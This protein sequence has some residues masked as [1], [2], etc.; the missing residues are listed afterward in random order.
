MGI[1]IS[2]LQ[3]EQSPPIRIELIR[4]L[5]TL[6]AL[7]P[8][9]YK[10]IQMQAKHRQ[11]DVVKNQIFSDDDEVAIVPSN[12]EY[13]PSVAISAL[14]RILSQ[15]YAR[16]SSSQCVTGYN[17]D[18]SSHGHTMCAVPAQSNASFSFTH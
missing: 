8:M 7:D 1:I 5:G 13:Y 2:G 9:E 10:Q 11:A 18:L 17:E 12:E 15:Q 16:N 4:L 6:G 14:I 3:S